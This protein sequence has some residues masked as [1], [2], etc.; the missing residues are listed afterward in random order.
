MQKIYKKIQIKT[1]L[2]IV[3]ILFIKLEK[4][5]KTL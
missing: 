2:K 3:K 1:E 4:H 5:Y